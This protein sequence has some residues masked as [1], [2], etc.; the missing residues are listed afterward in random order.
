MRVYRRAISYFRDDLGRIVTSQLVTVASIVLGLAWPLPLM[1]LIDRVLSSKGEEKWIYRAWNNFASDMTA[2]QQVLVLAGAM[3]TIRLLHEIL[4]PAQTLLNIRIGYNGMMRVRCDLFRKLQALSIGYHK[5]QPQGDAIYR[6]SYDTMGFQ[7][8]LNTLIGVMINVITLVAMTCIMLAMNVKLTLVSLTVTPFVFFAIRWYGEVLKKKYIQSYE[9][10]AQV[11]TAIQRSVSSIGL[12]QAFGREHDEFTRFAST[13]GNS[14]QVKM[15][16]HWH[17]IMYWLVLGVIFAVGAS[18]ILGY[19]G[20]LALRG[21]ITAGFLATFL[22][23]L[24]KLYDPLKALSGIGSGLQGEVA[25]V[26]RVFEV[27]DRDPIIRDAPDAIHLPRQARTLAFDRVGFEYDAGK[28]ILR[29]VTANIA[30]G[31]MVAFVGE[32]GV[33]KTTLLNLLPRF[34]DP[35][36][37]ALTLDGTDVRK[38][39]LADLRRHV[40]LVLQD[41]VILPTTVSENIAYG[42]PGATEAEIVQAA[43]LAG[44]A[45]FIN[46]LPQKFETMIQEAGSNLSGGQKQRISIARALLTEAPIIVLDEPT[47]ALDPQH[48]QLITET[49]KRLKSQRTIVLVSHRLSTVA[50]CDQIFVMDGGEIVERGKHDELI[51]RRGVYYRMARH[52][53]KLGDEPEPQVQ[54]ETRD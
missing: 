18:V 23:Y 49:L 50:D 24:E 38:I 37:G 12:V 48:E 7:G 32:S 16:L 1:V 53:L 39:R 36:S 34:Y 22:I 40:A 43:E 15:H 8:V 14:I 26:E 9:R 52:Q 29:D 3:L 4:R 33:G 44:A 28:P 54:A 19:G 42:R 30:V 5:S 47:S 11:T 35:T 10:D 27:L 13:Q 46:K 31:E 41:S 20:V 45:A 25:K 51:A 6:L 17:E 21:E 2:T